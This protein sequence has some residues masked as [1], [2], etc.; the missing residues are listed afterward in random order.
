MTIACG[1]GT[2][3][4]FAPEAFRRIGADVVE[5]QCD[6][7]YNFPNYNPNTE[8]LH[9]LDAMAKALKENGSEIALG[10]D[11]DGDRCGVV[12]DNGRGDLRRQDRRAASRATCRGA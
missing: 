3:G 1:N 7:D 5:A 4:L 9:M 8:D 11:A 2:A 6:P 10:F 12:D